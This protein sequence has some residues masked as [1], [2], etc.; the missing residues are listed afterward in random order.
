MLSQLPAVLGALIPLFSL[1]L[2]GTVLARRG[3][4]GAAFW[5]MLER[6]IY[7]I[8]FPALLIQSLASVPLDAERILPVFGAVLMTLGAGS[9]ALFASQAL[10]RLP[11][12]EFSSLYQ[13]GIRFNTYLGI[14]VMFSVFGPDVMATTALIIAV[15]IPLIN[16]ACVLVLAR[17]G[18]GSH[19]PKAVLT[20]LIRNPLIIACLIG[21][22][23]NLSGLQLHP[24]LLDT[25]DIAGSAAVPLGLMSVGAGLQITLARRDVLAIALVSVIK[26]LALPTAAWLVSQWVGLNPVEMQVL[27]VFAALPTATSAYILARQMGGDDAML[28]RLLTLQT[29]LAALTLP[30]ILTLLIGQ[31]S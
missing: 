24:W 16:V 10:L 17:F 30:W 31:G 1:I 8:L 12:P 7:F 28:A 27:V 6:F 25:M 20:Q 23:I 15:M 2:I 19:Q 22:A 14:A 26:L 13:G 3:F 29:A 4:P 9:I 5:P 21:L 11:G 18:T